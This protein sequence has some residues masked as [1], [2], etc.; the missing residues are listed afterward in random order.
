[1]GI[2]QVNEWVMGSLR[3]FLV[4]GLAAVLSACTS[5]DVRKVETSVVAALPKTS[6]VLLVRPDVQLSVQTVAGAEEPRADWSASAADNLAG[7]L[8]AWIAGRGHRAAAF[9]T[10]DAMDGRVG[11]IIRLN[12]VVA[13]SIMMVDYLGFNL[14]TK[15]GKFD[16]TLGPGTQALQAATGARYALFVG[17]RG[18]YADAGRVAAMVGMAIL[19]VGIPLGGQYLVVS[20]VDLETGRVLWF[21]IVS[22]LA[23]GPDMREPNG[24]TQLMRDLM[25]DA[26]L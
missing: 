9:D 26:P 23:G 16:W 5:S 19:G 1:M 22:V 3:K 7:A 24:A 18:A 8:D 11:Q 13:Q 25:K 12:N 17:A 10:A 21:N 20:L 15:R 14:P 4:V 2:D 6:Q